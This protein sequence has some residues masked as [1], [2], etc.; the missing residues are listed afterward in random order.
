M[1]VVNDWSIAGDGEEDESGKRQTSIRRQDKFEKE[2]G[3]KGC[4]HKGREVIK[5]K[6]NM[7]CGWGYKFV[8]KKRK[9]ERSEEMELALTNP[10]DI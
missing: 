2:G 6:K 1:R 3:W 4:G 8:T 10:L 7:G 5:V 9:A